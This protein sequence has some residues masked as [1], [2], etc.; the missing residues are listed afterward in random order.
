[1]FPF[2][3]GGAAGRGGG[4]A[5]ADLGA[6]RRRGLTR[7][8]KCITGGPPLFLPFIFLAR[9]PSVM[10]G[11]VWLKRNL[12][13]GVDYPN[14]VYFGRLFLARQLNVCST[15]CASLVSG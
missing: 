6:G 5:A 10:R 3:D 9:I 4:Q 2:D 14:A 7:C 8:K 11:P 15:Y 12:I 13:R 1:M